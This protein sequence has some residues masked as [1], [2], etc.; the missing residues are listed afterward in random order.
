[1][2]QTLLSLTTCA[3][4]LLGLA[5]CS[6]DTLYVANSEPVVTI[7]EPVEGQQFDEGT[8]VTLRGVVTDD[9]PVEDLLVEWISSVEGILPDEDP[10]DAEGN[11]EFVTAS[12]SQGPH[13]I[14]LR[15][16]DASN[17]QGESTVTIEILDVPDKPS[18]E[19]LHPT[20]GEAGLEGSPFIF[21][22]TVD[23]R[24]DL[25][26]DLTVSLSSNPG[27]F[28]C[29]LEIDGAGNSQCSATLG[30]ASYTLTFQVD[31]SD[32][33]TA[34]ALVEFQV[35]SA[36]DYD[37]D[38]DGYSVNGG[39]CNDSNDTI[40]P[41]AP[42]ICDGLDNDCSDETGTDVG[43]ECY[44]DDGDGYCEEPPCMNTE[45]TESDCDDTDPSISPE[46]EEVL[47]G[48]DD[49]C[50]GFVDEGTTAYDDDGDGFCETP[51]C[52]NCAGTE[53]DCDDED[54]TVYPGA[55]EVCG[56]D[57]DNNCDGIQNEQDAIG[58]FD[59]YYDYDGDT[60]GVAGM[61][62]CWCEDGSF[63]YT[64]ID[65]TDCYDSNA[66]AHPGQTA[67]FTADRGDGSYDYNCDGSDDKQYQD[68]SGGC[69]WD[70]IYI[71][72]ECNGEGWESSV[73]RCGSSD[74][75]ID[76]CEAVYDPVCYALCLLTADPISCLLTS[77][78]ATCD[79]QYTSLTQGC[80]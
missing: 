40:Y 79:P 49:D 58:C 73:P 78:G 70:M 63:P 38:G 74:L 62:E 35:L 57:V 66:S 55:T 69:A 8:A 3:C 64:G 77:C 54:Y 28:V 36:D 47:N 80:R 17:K 15:A 22:A 7:D 4:V 65:S 30:I 67:Y 16:T 9:S 6:D 27:G 60:Y 26:E 37:F 75:W 61:T 50:D 43:S 1:M 76:D 41:G 2:P 20:D 52:I 39:D 24:Q 44:D 68:V 25:A 21:M 31:D 10:P 23:D 14:T 12:L 32:G 56:D 71:S 72:C 48:V 34:Q 45:N 13:V 51:P 33:N 59:F 5:A 42:E 29:Y 53:S 18:I 46:A 11:V 19:V